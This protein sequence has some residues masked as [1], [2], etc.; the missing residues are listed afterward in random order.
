MAL[1]M[2]CLPLAGTAAAR[3]DTF[4][5]RIPAEPLSQALVDLALQTHLSIG[6]TGIDLRDLR[7]APLSGTFSPEEAL[8]RLLENSGYRFEFVDRSTVKI[9][10]ARSSS[11][12]NRSGASQIE[13]VVVTATKRDEIARQLPYSVS[14]TTARQL[15]D[16][17]AET[18]NDLASQVAQ[19]TTTNL[20][21]GQ[22]KVFLRGLTDSV[23]PG[24]S[25]SMVG[26]YL[27]ESRIA[28][29]APDPDLR[30]VDIDR[31]EIL[32]GPQGTLYG[33]GSLGGLL[34]I[35]TR[36]PVLDE[37]QA[38]ASTAVAATRH[39]S[40]SGGFDAVLNLP[41]VPDE[42]ALRLV[43]YVRRDGGYIDEARL[44]VPNA[45]RSRTEGGRVSARWQPA[46]SWFVD[47]AF[48]YQHIKADDSQYYDDGSPPLRRDN[49]LLEP[50]SDLFLNASVTL[51]ASLGWADLVSA[52]AIVDR[53][54]DERF[55]ATLAWP[56]LTGFPQG[57]SPFDDGRRIL[58]Y[59]HETRLVSPQDGR[60]KWLAGI[61][62]SHRDE[63]FHSTLAGPDPSGERI[64][65]RAESREDRANEAAVFGEATF[66][67]TDELSLTGGVRVF[68]A[69]RDVSAAVFSILKGESSST[70]KGSNNQSGATPKA[71]L[72]YRGNP[73]LMFYA[74]ASEGYRLG[75]LNVDGPPGSLGPD[76]ENAFDS[77]TLW[78]YE[79]G[80]KGKFFDGRLL[81]EAAVYY[82]RW[83]NVQADQIGPDGSFFIL[84][85]GTVHNVGFET[86]VSIL[87]VENLTLRGDFFWNSPK[88][89]NTNPLLTKTEGVLPAA[90][91]T[92]F[93]VSAR[94]EIP[95]GAAEAFIAADYGY[96]GRS[97]LG[98][99]E[100][101]SP[102]MGGYH[103]A[104]ARAGISYGN[105][106][107]VLYVNNLEREDENTFGFGNPFDP[108]P[109]LTPP[110]PRTIGLNL[111]W[112]S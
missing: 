82:D 57:P 1:G 27:D 89:T 20:G 77:D 48:A 95:L 59:T 54:L 43:G 34:R 8:S 50:H 11:P 33:G 98:F 28:D 93:G 52:T 16:L 106:E 35:V 111:S 15:E 31:V 112:H 87:P 104:N 73:N 39:G 41:I 94:Y 53:H 17:R 32:N 25:E 12:V 19:L 4:S 46:A 3:A 92:K 85:A 38:M 80:S 71:I 109:Q 101:S 9:V 22:D 44:N 18:I 14:V 6:D 23:V 79:I 74:Q 107:A 83:K 97:H 68:N 13:I 66:A 21:A 75:G 56:A 90:P 72:E 110:R 86:D 63:D 103:I 2:L 10:A 99:D 88:L 108:N 78:N 105:W 49:Y 102:M 65:G 51:R 37:F 45:N 58:S 62:L 60:W 5:I 69:A 36:K 30:L 67:F 64:V 24:L 96:V 61:F 7:S 91:R 100:A 29:D 70:F 42:L 47:A 81:T 84:N 26:I 76:D 55:D 40:L